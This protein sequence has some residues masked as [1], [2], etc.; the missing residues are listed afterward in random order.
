MKIINPSYEILTPISEGGVAELQ[1][2]ERAART[3]Y[4]SEDKATPD[5]ESA[6]KM[7]AMLIKRGHEAM[8]EHGQ[9]SVRFVCDRGISH[10]LVRHRLAAFAQ[11]STR[12][13]NYSG[14]KFGNEIT[15]IKPCFFREGT[16]AYEIWADAC[17]CCEE[18]YFALLAEGRKPEEA[19]SVL[20]NS[21]ATTIVVT[22]NW[23][24]W[25]HILRLRTANDAHPQMCELMRPLLAELKAKVPI[26]FDDIGG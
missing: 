6:K 18:S 5:G 8:L 7:A 2:I 25:R 3:C 24:E 12:W 17:A 11:S 4:R 9:L 19:R 20:P 26:L 16:P 15:V 22:A 23:R 10:E 13:C 14:G 21:L 1:A